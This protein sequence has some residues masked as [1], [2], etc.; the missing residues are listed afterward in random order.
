MVDANGHPGPKSLRY[1]KY[2][3]QWADKRFNAGRRAARATAPGALSAR[4][5]SS[6][7]RLKGEQ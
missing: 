5:R 6:F 3:G 7:V 4:C 2:G 1:I